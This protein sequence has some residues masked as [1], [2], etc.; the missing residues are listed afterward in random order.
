MNPLPSHVL[1]LTALAAALSMVAPPDVATL[2]VDFDGEIPFEIGTHG[3][4]GS[5]I[6][7]DSFGEPVGANL[8]FLTKPL[9]T[10]GSDALRHGLIVVR[11]GLPA[12]SLI[13]AREHLVA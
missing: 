12:S 1:V 11:L 8:Q 3:T 7:L 13:G 2:A 10:N 9:L 6:P 5:E 4:V